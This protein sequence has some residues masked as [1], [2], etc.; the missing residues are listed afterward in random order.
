MYAGLQNVIRSEMVLIT[1]EI[2]VLNHF[3]VYSIFLRHVIDKGTVKTTSKLRLLNLHNM[4][5]GYFQKEPKLFS[6]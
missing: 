4:F 3:V 6:C 2:A 1:K 5:N